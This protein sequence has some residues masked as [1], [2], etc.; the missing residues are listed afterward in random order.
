MAH[1]ALH[2]IRQWWG[3]KIQKSKLDFFFIDQVTEQSGNKLVIFE[4]INYGY[5][6]HKMKKKVLISLFDRQL[7]NEKTN[8]KQIEKT[9]QIMHSEI[10]RQVK[11]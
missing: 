3:L 10:G 8:D 9:E 1:K 5:I 7:K 4:D 2:P 6:S 11:I